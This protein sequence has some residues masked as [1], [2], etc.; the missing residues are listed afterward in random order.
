[1]PFLRRV[2]NLST[3][4]LKRNQCLRRALKE[5]GFQTHW[6]GLDLQDVIDDKFFANIEHLLRCVRQVACIAI[7]CLCFK[8]MSASLLQLW[9]RQCDNDNWFT[10]WPNGHRPL[11]TTW[12]WNV[13]PSLLVLWG[14]C[15]MFYYGDHSHTSNSGQADS[16]RAEIS[17]GHDF[18]TRPGLWTSRPISQQPQTHA[19][20]SQRAGCQKMRLMHNLALI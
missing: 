16:G 11:S 5:E 20:K 13:R 14:V 8:V 15:W 17:F 2:S 1:M 10:E 6:V 12:P 7:A 19:G 18:R 3:F 4:L 9:S